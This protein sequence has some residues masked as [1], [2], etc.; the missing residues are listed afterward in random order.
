MFGFPPHCHLENFPLNFRKIPSEICPTF[1]CPWFFFEANLLWIY[2]SKT[3][4]WIS[5][6]NTSEIRTQNL[7]RIVLETP[8]A[9]FLETNPSIVWKASL[10]YLKI[11]QRFLQYIFKKSSRNW[12]GMAMENP[13]G[14]CPA[15]SSGIHPEISAEV[16]TEIS[17]VCP[18]DIPLGIT[19]RISPGIL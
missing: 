17:S 19:F 7:P 4:P 12:S 14:I 8:P 1:I 16:N 11:F 10:R 15:L 5:T 3:A 6:K 13:A 18:S 9:I 2:F